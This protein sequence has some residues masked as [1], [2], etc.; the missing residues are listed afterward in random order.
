MSTSELRRGPGWWM[1]LD[2][3]W[4]PPESWPESSPPLPGWIRSADGT[5]H[6]PTGTATTLVE[7][8]VDDVQQLAGSD[9]AQVEDVAVPTQRPVPDTGADSGPVDATT[10]AAAIEDVNQAPVELP[11]VEIAPP[12]QKPVPAPT[13]QFSDMEAVVQ[14]TIDEARLVRRAIR[15][16]IIAGVLAAMIGIGLALLLARL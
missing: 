9:A 14:P 3:S 15:A 13:L 2:G 4:N 16:A 5:W 12:T 11:P 6:E 1:D 10:P 7:T 8:K